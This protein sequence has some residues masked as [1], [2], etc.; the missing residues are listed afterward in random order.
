MGNIRFGWAERKFVFPKPVA[1]MGQFAERISEYEEKPLTVTALA[2]DNGTEQMV[3]CSTDL[4]GVFDVLRDGVRQRIADNKLGL[5]PENVIICATHIHTGPGYAGYGV[6]TITKNLISQT[7][8]LKQNLPAGKKF[9]ERVNISNN[10]ALMS[11]ED[12]LEEL[13][14]KI[15]DAALSAWENR[16]EGAFVNAFGR[17]PI[18]QCRRVSFSDGSAQMWGDTYSAAFTALEGGNDSGIEL[19]Y[20]FDKEDKLTGIVANLACPAQCVQHRLFIS[21]D[22]WGEAKMLLR[23]HFG[24]EIFLLPLCSAAGDQCPADLVRF[25]E[26]ESDLNDPNLIRKDLPKRNAGPSMFDLP[27]MRKNGKRI[28]NEIIDVFEEGLAPKISDAEF[29]HLVRTVHLPIRRATLQEELQAKAG[30]RAYMMQK[31]DDADFNDLA[32]LQ[33]FLGPLQ[34][35]VLQQKVDIMDVEMHIARLGNIA[36]AT[37]PFELFLDYGNQMKARSLAEQT[38][39][40]QLACGYEGYLPTEKAEKGGHYSAFHASTWVGHQGGE[41]LVRETLAEINKLFRED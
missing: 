38:F 11:A 33:Q 17:A 12:R 24:E 29:C 3:L 18:G 23:K 36:I 35:M 25:V 16:A 2:V 7:D 28:A 41:Q 19:L 9:V 8:I 37:N 4:L 1:L 40:V 6:R 32:N 13:V 20:I 27:G 30:I 34:R 14:S 31:E 39:V 21:P 15:A 26:P 10:D 22:F 5:K